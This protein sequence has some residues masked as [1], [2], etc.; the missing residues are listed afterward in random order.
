MTTGGIIITESST[1]IEQDLQTVQ[2]SRMKREEHVCFS[3]RK[4]AAG[5]ITLLVLQ[6]R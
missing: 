1:V 5:L 3:H 4:S 2:W 6:T